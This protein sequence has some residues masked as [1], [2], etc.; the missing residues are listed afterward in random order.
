ML[1]KQISLLCLAFIT[2]F[3]S[4]QDSHA[5]NTNILN[6]LTMIEK[7]QYSSAAPLLEKEIAKTRDQKTK[8]YYAFLLSQLPLNIPTKRHDMNT[9]L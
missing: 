5:A 7:K 4:G 2:L 8:G 9:S 1:N 3:C 6:I